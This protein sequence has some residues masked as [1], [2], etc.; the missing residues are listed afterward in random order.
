M[1]FEQELHG[2]LINFEYSFPK[3]KFQFFQTLLKNNLLK[4]FRCLPVKGKEPLEA[5]PVSLALH[6]SQKK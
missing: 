2:S 6:P 3:G 1:K 5:L 4:A